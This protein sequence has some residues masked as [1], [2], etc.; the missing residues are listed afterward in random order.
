MR[1]I[2]CS[3][4]EPAFWPGVVLSV[5]EGFFVLHLKQ[6]YTILIAPIVCRN[7][8]VTSAGVTLFY[9]SMARS[10]KKEASE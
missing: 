5:P 7:Y 1:T 3:T 9:S 6:R 2:H 8:A 10:A 4:T